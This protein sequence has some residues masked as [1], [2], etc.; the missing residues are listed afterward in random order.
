MISYDTP[1]ACLLWP[2]SEFHIRCV[3]AAI[4]C[5]TRCI[6]PQSGHASNRMSAQYP[7]YTLQHALQSL[8]NH[9]QTSKTIHKVPY[10]PDHPSTTTLSIIPPPS[11]NNTKHKPSYE[12][13]KQS[14]CHSHP[15]S[16][17]PSPSASS[18]AVPNTDA[19][20]ERRSE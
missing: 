8:T 10:L 16:P 7:R 20:P 18:A 15:P 1:N 6:A 11:P 4:V 14:H 19:R 9:H 3:C 13:Y 5:N 12:N 17:S 2:F